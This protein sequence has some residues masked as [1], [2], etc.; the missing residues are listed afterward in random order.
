MNLQWVGR[1]RKST[2]VQMLFADLAGQRLDLLVRQLEEIVEQ[3]ELVHQ[4]ERRRMH[5]VAAK[6][7]KK[8]GILFQ[9]DD[10]DAG[11]RQQKTKH[12]SG[13]TAAGDTAFC[14]QR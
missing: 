2:I 1:W 14:C 3:A 13:G 9:H 4:F 8:I 7:A 12:H 6:I 10:I 5:G 11:A